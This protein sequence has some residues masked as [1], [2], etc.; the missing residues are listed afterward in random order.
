V[1][2]SAELCGHGRQYSSP[3]PSRSDFFVRRPAGVAGSDKF[4]GHGR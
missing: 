2:G 4:C 1:A 3:G